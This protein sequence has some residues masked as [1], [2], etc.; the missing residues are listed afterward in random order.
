MDYN[1]KK[2]HVTAEGEAIR[3]D[4]EQKLRDR[5]KRQAFSDLAYKAYLENRRCISSAP[6]HN[7]GCPN[8]IS[9]APRHAARPASDHGATQAGG[10]NESGDSDS[11][12]DPDQ[13]DPP[14]PRH[15][16]TSPNPNCQGILYSS[17][18][19]WQR[20]GSW[21]MAERGRAA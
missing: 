12:S 11:S 9:R 6:K 21:R 13:G 20:P 19:P 15:S 3:L 2:R 17:S 14:G 7:T 4:Y 5:K 10:D 8:Q 18:Y 1:M 16:V